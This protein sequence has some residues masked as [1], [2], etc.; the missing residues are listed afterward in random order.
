MPVRAAPVGTQIADPRRPQP[1]GPS[2][3]D[4]FGRA[5]TTRGSQPLAP[6][7]NTTT[8]SGL[9]RLAAQGYFFDENTQTIARMVDSA[10]YG[11]ENGV[12]D[13]YQTDQGAVQAMYRANG[14]VYYMLRDPQT[15]ELRE[16]DLNSLT[17]LRPNYYANEAE[18]AESQAQRQAVIDQMAAGTYEGDMASNKVRSIGERFTENFA[19]SANNTP[20]LQG[21][22]ALLN[23]GDSDQGAFLGND[24]VTGLPIY[25]ASLG[26]Q[27]RDLRRERNE[28]FQRRSAADTF[29]GDENAN[30]M[31]K[32][33]R[34]LATGVG[35]LGGQF[36][37]PVNM[38]GP[39][40]TGNLA[41][42]MM[43]EAAFNAVVDAAAS[44]A[45]T[46]QH[47]LSLEK[48]R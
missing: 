47:L 25:E 20:I 17:G 48:E 13:W 36:V 30:L 1:E 28:D 2:G 33:L 21:V 34:G 41:T 5:F 19:N 44:L 24:P 7:E 11:D 15:D 46:V 45:D 27:L 6:G 22:T 23:R 14:T 18:Q 26:A 42:N 8:T 37:D 32:G 16:V 35:Q 4:M 40:G 29:Y 9:N 38:I 39:K 31:T 43:R 10:Y 12:V 3:T